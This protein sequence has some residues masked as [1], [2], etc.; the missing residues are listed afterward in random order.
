LFVITHSLAQSLTHSQRQ[1]PRP[2]VWLTL[3]FVVVW[4]CSSSSTHTLTHSLTLTAPAPGSPAQPARRQ[5]K[6]AAK[7]AAGELDFWFGCR[8]VVGVIAAVAVAVPH[9][10]LTCSLTCSLTH[11]R[12][13]LQRQPP[14]PQS[15]R[16]VRKREAQR[17]RQRVSGFFFWLVECF[18]WCSCL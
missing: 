10:S 3:V 2:Q 4:C 11:S 13:Y 8:L 17:S 18:V 14:R 6:T 15:P 5:A 1:L 7:P 9:H 12:I 16:P